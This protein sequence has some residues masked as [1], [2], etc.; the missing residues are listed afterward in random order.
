MG[1]LYMENDVEIRLP[2][3]RPQ[4]IDELDEI[5]FES[6][7]DLPVGELLKHVHPCVKRAEE[8]SDFAGIEVALVR[9]SDLRDVEIEAAGV[10]EQELVNGY[11]GTGIGSDLRKTDFS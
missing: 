2:F 8:E 10:S 9:E 1:I 6:A 11:N 4:V 7:R 3:E 5:G